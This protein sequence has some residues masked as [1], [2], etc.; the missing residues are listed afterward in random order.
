MTVR[1]ALLAA[2]L[3]DPERVF[4]EYFPAPDPD[5]VEKAAVARG[6]DV[7]YDYSDVSWEMPGESGEDPEEALRLLQSM[8]A[9]LSLSVGEDDWKPEPEPE[10]EAILAMDEGEREW[11]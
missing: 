2:R 7:E 3:A 11:L 4:P 5:E 10:P 1:A 6:D 9:N 8:G